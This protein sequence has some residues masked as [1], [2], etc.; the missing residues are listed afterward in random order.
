LFVNSFT[1]EN[2]DHHGV[3]PFFALAFSGYFHGIEQAGD[4]SGPQ[5]LIDVHAFDRGDDL[6]FALVGYQP[7]PDQALA[8]G[9]LFLMRRVAATAFR[10]AE[11]PKTG[12]YR[13]RATPQEDGDFLRR[14][15]VYEV[16]FVEKTLVQILWKF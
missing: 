5:A 15:A 3:I 13:R 10:E 8:I 2:C 14:K 11:L 9:E 7:M 1:F 4:G 6:E 12:F 16:F